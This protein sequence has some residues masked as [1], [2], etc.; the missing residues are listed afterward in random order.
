[1][2]LCGEQRE[3]GNN[4]RRSG[5]RACDSECEDKAEARREKKGFGAGALFVLV[6]RAER[7]GHVGRGAGGITDQASAG[8]CGAALP[9]S[10]PQ[11]GSRA[12][13]FVIRQYSCFEHSCGCGCIVVGLP[14]LKV[15]LF[16]SPTPSTKHQASS[17]S[18]SIST[19]PKM[20]FH[21]GA[22]RRARRRHSTLGAPPLGHWVPRRPRLAAG[23]D[24][25]LLVDAPAAG[26]PRA[27][28]PLREP[29][30]RDERAC[31]LQQKR[32][33]PAP[34]RE[35]STWRALRARGLDRRPRRIYFFISRVYRGVRLPMDARSSTAVRWGAMD[36]W[37][38]SGLR[39]CNSP[40]RSL[41]GAGGRTWE[42]AGATPTGPKSKSL[43]PFF[44]TSD[45]DVKL[46]KR[47][48]LIL[49]DAPGAFAFCV[50]PLLLAVWRS[51]LSSHRP[52]SETS[53]SLAARLGCDGLL[54]SHPAF[55]SAASLHHQGGD[56][57]SRLARGAGAGPFGPF[58][59]NQHRTL[60]HPDL[61]GIGATRAA[62]IRRGLVLQTA[63]FGRTVELNAC[64]LDDSHCPPHQGST[65]SPG[66]LLPLGTATVKNLAV[67]AQ[68]PPD[69]ARRSQSLV[70]PSTYQSASPRGTKSDGK[71]GYRLAWLRLPKERPPCDAT[72]R[73]DNMKRSSPETPQC[74]DECRTTWQDDSD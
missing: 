31:K 1:M 13:D 70:V 43:I 20:L 36:R 61:F 59:S 48:S 22:S 56:S 9:A 53:P 54:V 7:G 25:A 6:Q 57:A 41:G 65:A 46:L 62:R 4:N 19:T 37:M 33:L 50:S 39:L 40:P 69:T 32:Y 60:Q 47:R 52:R 67:L 63:S 15:L 68:P 10:P 55:H 24:G 58:G 30:R 29:R 26:Q 38:D 27:V 71:M 12:A 42:A 8:D 51:P 73:A 5:A 45:R 35:M 14:I 74:L 44:P 17:I 49:A 11:G 23:G 21:A 64:S 34:A 66:P 72:H 2:T 16:C 28:S 18:T 3:R